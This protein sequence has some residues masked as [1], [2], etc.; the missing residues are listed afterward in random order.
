MQSKAKKKLIKR[1][2][3]ILTEKPFVYVLH[4][5]YR[6]ERCDNCL[7][8]G[9]VLKCS[10]CQYVYYCNRACQMQ[11]WI[12]HKSECNS[13]KKIGSRI[14]P[15]AARI[16]SKIIIKLDSG[17]DLTKSYYTETSFRRFKDL[18]SHYAEL[19]NDAK[20]VEH[21][22]AL[23]SVLCE[24]MEDKIV[25][26]MSELMGIY[27]RLVTNGFNILDPEMNAIATG[28][29]LGVSVTDHSCK[30]NAVATFEGTELHIHATEDMEYLDWSKIFIS[31]IDLLNTPEQRRQELSDNYFFLCI[32]SKC[33]DPQETVEMNG[34][35][36][37]NK[38]CSEMVNMSLNNC[39][40][41][42]TGIS[43]KHRNAYNEVLALTKLHLENMKETTYLDICK[44][45]LP[46]QKGVLHPMSLW[47][48]KTL[49]AAVESA[50]SM[51]KWNDALEFAIQLLPGFR[52]YY[53]MWNPL[54]GLLYVKVAKLQL[55]EG[56]FKEAQHNL[57]EAFK[58]I[59]ITHGRD[60]TLYKETLTTLMMQITYE[61]SK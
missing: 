59:E 39:S 31:Y 43:P 35:V 28:I 3:R 8:S 32:C 54:L 5:K 53:G 33:I 49:D 38:N 27:G 52:K 42:G 40:K 11:S 14:V 30:P 17:G 37:P 9:K 41:C 51:E 60:H 50:F 26:N 36:C 10:N 58:I 47:H 12:M 13:L 57:K 29:Y 23:H 24:L 1:G 6:K 7:V 21:L 61:L 46:R 15:D 4:S 55:Y 34:G 25:P 48:V 19:K 18:M 20:R 44:M 16:L 22:E 2:D 56:F 45:C